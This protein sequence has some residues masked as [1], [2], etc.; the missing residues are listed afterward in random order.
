MQDDIKITELVNNFPGVCAV[1]A[2]R[3]E[4]K[5]GFLALRPA[6]YPEGSYRWVVISAEARDRLASEGAK[7][8]G[9]AEL[10]SIVIAGRSAASHMG[11]GMRGR[12]GKN[13]GMA[14]TETW[15]HVFESNEKIKAGGGKPSTDQEIS[16]FMKKEFPDQP[17]KSKSLARVRMYR[18][19][20]N[21]ATHGFERWGKPAV[22]SVEYNPQGNPVAPGTAI[23]E[24]DEDARD[25][26]PAT[27]AEVD[28]NRVRAIAKEEA[29]VAASGALPPQI[30]IH[31]HE[32]KQ[33]KVDSAGKHK[34]FE[35]VL[36]RVAA[37]LNVLL[38]GPKGC[39]KS[40]L[41]GQVAEALKLPFT[42]NSMS[43][44]VSESALLGRVIPD[45]K[46]RWEYHESPFVKSF[47]DGGVH[48][49]DEI[50]AADPNLLVQV[51]AA[52][53]NGILS[54]PQCQ[55][56]PIKRHNDSIII[57]AANTYGTGANREY[58]GRNQLD[59]S[60]LDRF[61]MGTVEVTYDKQL[62][63]AIAKAIMG[64]GAATAD[65]LEFFWNTRDK[66]ESSKMRRGVSTRNVED[67]AKLA[68]AGAS[69][70]EIKQ[71]FFQSWGE[72]E[73]AKVALNPFDLRSGSSR[74]VSARSLREYNLSM[75]PAM[76]GLN[77]GRQS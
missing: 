54:I 32:R 35:T 19:C 20:Y 56:E 40:H 31:Y 65:L 70:D 14:V 36:K 30:T 52:L 77:A 68:K 75:P 7:T 72:D 24:L 62:E 23:D 1:T 18:T 73:K 64:G 3:V 17:A 22:P 13:L 51:N 39:G 27:Q 11:R 9:A 12:H 33:V 43:E 49:L 46:G 74:D 42:L 10:A 15:R 47:R 63:A 4:S 25:F 50:D 21:N 57:A 29:K 53:A 59:A 61:T 34:A 60:T 76:N 71:I 55:A 26:S 45:S 66:C 69:L 41:V 2:M 37:G 58:V 44:G 28:W 6:S 5:S 48:L 16:D 8:M 38:V 67:A